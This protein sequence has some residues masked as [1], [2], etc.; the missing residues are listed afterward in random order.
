MTNFA[1]NQLLILTLPTFLQFSFAVQY[2][3]YSEILPIYDTFVH[4]YGSS[5]SLYPVFH[6]LWER[7]ISLPQ[8]FACGLLGWAISACPFS[9]GLHGLLKHCN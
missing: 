4:F 8:S 6:R 7:L 2:A 5:P 9:S 3:C 1:T